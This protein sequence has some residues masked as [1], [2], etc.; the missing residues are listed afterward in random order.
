[1]LKKGILTENKNNKNNRNIINK[2]YSDYLRK[3]IFSSNSQA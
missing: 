3:I 2:T 1:M